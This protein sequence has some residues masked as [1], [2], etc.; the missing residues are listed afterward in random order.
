MVMP[1]KQPL[2]VSEEDIK[3]MIRALSRYSVRCQI[4][5][6]ITKVLIDSPHRIPNVKVWIPKGTRFDS[7]EKVKDFYLNEIAV[8]DDLLK[9]TKELKKRLRR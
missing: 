4:Q 1:E 9:A 6:A 2:Y 8:V 5:F 7:N 3:T